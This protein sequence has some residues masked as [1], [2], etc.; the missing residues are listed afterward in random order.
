[1]LCRKTV[2]WLY[3]LDR[4]FRLGVGP[5]CSTR[6]CVFRDGEGKVRLIVES[7]GRL[8]VTRRYSWNGCSPKVC[9]LDLLMRDAGRRRAT[10]PPAGRR[11]TTP[12]SCTTRCAEFL[13]A[14]SPITR[15]QA[16]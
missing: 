16:D 4:N 7:G 3:R 5:R 2:T 8:T 10:N 1:M 13:D 15:A 14:G 9:V 11:P 12:P 6:I